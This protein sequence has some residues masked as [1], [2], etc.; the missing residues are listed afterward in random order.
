MQNTF[1]YIGDIESD[2]EENIEKQKN[3]FKSK[4]DRSNIIIFDFEENDNEFDLN[5]KIK[6]TY[7]NLSLFATK[8]LVILK[9]IS[10][11]LKSKDADDLEVSEFVDKKD[12][13]EV[14]LN[15][16]R[17]TDDNIITVMQDKHIDKRSK[18]F[19]E[20]Q[21]MEKDE[22]LRLTELSFNEKYNIENW[23]LKIIKDNNFTITK[24]ALLK[25]L[26][27][28]NIRKN[29]RGQ[30]EG[31]FNTIKIKNQLLKL[32]NFKQDGLIKEE[33]INKLDLN[34]EN[35]NDDDIFE[36]VNLI[37][38]KDKNALK[39][40]EKN[41]YNNVNEKLKLD[42]LVFFNTI[43]INQLEELISIKDLMEKNNSDE[44]I[45]SIM[46]WKN[47]KKIYPVK[48]KI[49]NFSREELLAN[50]FKFEEI[51]KLSKTDQDICLYKL[52]LLVLDIVN[53]N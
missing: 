50:Y 42:E 1:V 44:E 52:N 15:Y 33:D 53:K 6:S 51:D 29:Y 11:I 45:A 13:Q 39:L 10:N 36:L 47:P 16:I 4:Y 21:K 32:F 37:F 35:P 2:I 19:K 43:M 3:N 18:F 7:E 48:L 46:G 22:K 17:K 25:I 23:I 26:E 38:Q 20:L 49:R 9:N 28:F 27:K 5:Q 24:N 41:F 30:Y 34:Y 8:K 40:F 31:F 12:L 14:L